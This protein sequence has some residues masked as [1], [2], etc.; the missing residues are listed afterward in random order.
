MI[1]FETSRDD[2]FMI[3]LRILNESEDDQIGYAVLRCNEIQWEDHEYRFWL[4]MRFTNRSF[5]ELDA[6]CPNIQFRVK[7]SA[8]FS[9]KR[10]FRGMF[11]DNYELGKAIGDGSFSQVYL[12][13]NKHT[14]KVFA[15]K[16]ID[17]SGDN[18]SR[19][20]S[21]YKEIE[22]NHLLK[23]DYLIRL[24]DQFHEKSQIYLVFELAKGGELFGYIAQR[25]FILPENSTRDII[26]QLLLGTAYMHS[27]GIAHRDLKLE[28]IVL[29]N[30]QCPLEIKIIDFGLSIDINR[31]VPCYPCGS[32]E[33]L[34]PEILLSKPYDGT[35]ADMWAIGVITFMLLGGYPP[36]T[37]T[38]SQMFQRI[39]KGEY[40]FGAPVWE[41]ISPEAKDFIRRLLCRSPKRRMTAIQCLRSP[42]ITGRR[43][44]SSV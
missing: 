10:N 23:S 13:T 43:R 6:R 9:Q 22:I 15:V 40:S 26:H 27:S 21:I 16:I 39:Y 37:G 12:A 1:E 5:L 11:N 35:A 2:S 14:D 24:V 36:F 18:A 20:E 38:L 29:M 30:D 17:I 32:P 34:A 25:E 4:K 3:E 31:T 33:Y 28:N 19:I 41:S 42:W 44:S 7:V 8:S